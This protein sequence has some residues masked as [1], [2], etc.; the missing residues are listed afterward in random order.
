MISKRSLSFRAGYLA[1]MPIA[2][3]ILMQSSCTRNDW[4]SRVVLANEKL[5]ANGSIRILRNR[6]GEK[7][8]LI[9]LD[10]FP[11]DALIQDL[12]AIRGHCSTAE[13]KITTTSLVDV[14]RVAAGF[15]NDMVTCQTCKFSTE[16][17]TDFASGRSKKRVTNGQHGRVLRFIGCHIDAECLKYI[18]ER[19]VTN[20]SDYFFHACVITGNTIEINFNGSSFRM[21]ETQATMGGGPKFVG[22]PKLY[23]SSVRLDGDFIAFFKAAPANT[24]VDIVNCTDASGLK[25]ER[26]EGRFESA[27]DSKE[28]EFA[29]ETI[30][31]SS[32]GTSTKLQL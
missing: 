3:I 24:S 17:I 12:I 32:A 13:I 4:D 11:G 25:I 2:I 6:E 15:E 18:V 27:P 23:V 28:R 26:F 1:W 14:C 29:I 8:C 22:S 9:N 5:G 31:S 30:L 16:N 7:Y 20:V 21:S 10:K 19:C